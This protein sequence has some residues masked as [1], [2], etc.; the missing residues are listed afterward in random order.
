[1]YSIED[2]KELFR[3]EAFVIG[4]ADVISIRTA[5][6][7]FGLDAVEHVRVS[8]R[9]GRDWNVHS[10]RAGSLVYL[11]FDGALMA[12]TYC[13]LEESPRCKRIRK[14]APFRSR[15]EMA[16]RHSQHS[17]GRRP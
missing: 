5:V 7:A 14:A 12:A 2:V 15:E 11:T 6:E 3:D 10:D 9:P 16:G 1:M 17:E 4:W 8:G 13:N